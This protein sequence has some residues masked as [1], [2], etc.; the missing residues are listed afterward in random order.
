MT[1][2]AIW[3]D[4]VIA[5]SD[6]PLE[7]GEDVW[8]PRNDVNLDHLQE[9]PPG[10]GGPDEEVERHEAPGDDTPSDLAEAQA[11][12]SDEEDATPPGS[13]PSGGGSGPTTYD[14]RVDGETLE[15]AART[16]PPSHEERRNLREHVTFG[17]G[18][19]IVD[20]PR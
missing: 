5:E 7:V 6:E 12:R 19:R 16:G 10:G 17:R 11:G 8:F 18:V 20:E 1:K 4:T 14:L 15:E 9:S 13:D 3:K 2:R